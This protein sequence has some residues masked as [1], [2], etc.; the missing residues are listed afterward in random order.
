MVKSL[1]SDMGIEKLALQG[2][3]GAKFDERNRIFFPVEFR[4]QVDMALGGIDYYVILSPTIKNSS[5][6]LRIDPISFEDYDDKVREMNGKDENDPERIR[7]FKKYKDTLDNQGRFRVTSLL[8]RM[9]GYQKGREYCFV[10]NGEYCELLKA[11]REETKNL[12]FGE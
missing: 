11:N 5:E 1:L 6:V 12:I 4:D 10:G 2:T 7:F 3:Y 9:M 8:F